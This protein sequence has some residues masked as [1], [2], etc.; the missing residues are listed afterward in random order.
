MSIGEQIKAL[1]KEKGWSQGRL[2]KEVN[3]SQAAIS[4]AESNDYE[5]LTITTLQRIASILGK[6]V[7]IDLVR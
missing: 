7:V 5:K 1:R 2:A 6:E 3:T 4:M